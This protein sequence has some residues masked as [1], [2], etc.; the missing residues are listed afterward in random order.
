MERPNTV[1]GL[2]EKRRTLAARL[3]IV[4]GEVQALTV[5]I[6]ALDTVLRLFAPEID[7]RTLKAK[8][9]PS[10][11]HAAKG[12]LQRL[13]LDTIRETGGPVT[14]LM[15]AERFCAAR[16]MTPDDRTIITIRGR[17]GS[18]IGKMKQKGALCQVPL[19]GTYKGWAQPDYAARCQ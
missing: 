19:A 9:L 15:V 6:D 16:G 2:M 7:G 10:P 8:R 13:V 3:K 18:I 11:F 5:D 17:V 1:A 4:Q 12:E 14:S